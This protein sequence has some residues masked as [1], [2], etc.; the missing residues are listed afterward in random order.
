MRLKLY[1]R[2]NICARKILKTEL[3]IYIEWFQV[4]KS[5]FHAPCAGNAVLHC[6]ATVLAQKR[7]LDPAYKRGS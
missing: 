2:R 3:S 4:I 6:D 5:S 7:S 1:C